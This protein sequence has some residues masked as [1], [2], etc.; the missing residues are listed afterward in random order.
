M[1]EHS[2]F[3]DSLNPLDPDKVYTADEFMGF[4]VN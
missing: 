2:K 4:S 1:A 3:F